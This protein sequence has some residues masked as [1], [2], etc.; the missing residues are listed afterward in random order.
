MYQTLRLILGDQLNY[1]HSCFSKV[2]PDV[3]YVLMEV[4]SETD[5]AMHH[6]QKVVGIF[7]AM[8]N[9]KN[10]LVKRG[11][12]VHYI[13]INDKENKQTLEAN[14]ITLIKRYSIAKFEYFLPDE[15]RVDREL[16]L[17]SQGLS[18][19]TGVID[20]EHFFTTRLEL[21][22]FFGGKKY[23]MEN[24]YR[25]IRKK[26][27]ILVLDN[28][29]IGGKWNYD[30]ENRRKYSGKESI[31]SV[32]K[33]EKNLIDILQEIEKAG[34]K[35]IGNAKAEAFNWPVTR[36]ESLAVLKHFLVHSLQHFG[37][38]QDAMVEDH[39]YLFHSR[40]SFALNLKMI[41]PKEVIDAAIAYQ[42]H[43]STIITMPQLEG[44]VRQII[45]W[46][47][48]MRGIY[49]AKMPDFSMMNFFKHGNKLPQWYWTGATK[50]KCLQQSIQGSLENAYAHHIQR[51]MITG[52]F[53]LLA[54]I[55]PQL[56]D[57]WYLGIYIDAFEWVEITNTRGMS[58]YADGGIVG[59]KPYVSSANYID[60]MS[61]Y[62][63]K[64]YYDKKKRHGKAACPFNSLYWHFYNR[65]QPLLE[66]NPRIGMM[67]QTWKKMDQGEQS[68]ILNQA[69]EY[70]TKLDEL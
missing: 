42:A 11:H 49:W 35:T 27:H 3:L 59:S 44:F 65:H 5:Y 25:Y 6:A 39:A 32:L 48:Y 60:K 10:W 17:F 55:D 8:F 40:L 12:R 62:C 50:M 15:Y 7:A 28:E 9:F 24:F 51:L 57:E 66:K 67:Y 13:R 21:Q 26:H 46:R 43:H 4:R 63:S 41:S 23:L 33:L 20:T 64:C 30:Q 58:Q 1:N 22:E 68:K 31:P 56:V 52:N 47:E 37:T 2:E 54:G 45:G 16:N 14:L 70:L 61:N 36:K 18:I 29:P 38:Y 19:K 34:V 53:A 69:N